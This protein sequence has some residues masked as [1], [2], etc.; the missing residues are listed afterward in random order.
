MGVDVDSE[1][2]ARFEALVARRTGDEPLQY[3]EGSVPFGP[4][5]IAVDAR[6]LVPRPETE[7]LF[8]MVTAMVS[9][10]KMIVDLCTGSG[11]LALAC[12]ATFPDASVYATDLSADAIAVAT[13]NAHSNGLDVN[14]LTGDLFE[15]LPSTLRSKVDVLVANPPYLADDELSGVPPDVRREPTMA[16][17]SG[18]QGDE[19][20]YRIAEGLGAW[21]RPG[22][23]FA[24]E[25]SE[26]HAH[27]VVG[28]FA[29]HDARVVQDLTGRDRYVFGSTHVK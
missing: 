14:I 16:L 12:K 9:S 2:E 13:S 15:P 4:V 20:V 3:I 5:D 25:V 7:Y 26:F 22:G 17:V 8:E 19:I 24:I 27:R 11:N 1:T 6:V 23:L 28:F 29:Q 21:L 18:P 10:P